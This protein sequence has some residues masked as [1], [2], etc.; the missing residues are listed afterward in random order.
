[1]ATRFGALFCS[2]ARPPHRIG[3]PASVCRLPLPQ[4]WGRSFGLPPAPP[5]ES[6][7][8]LR[9]CRP[10]APQNWGRSF[11]LPP[12]PPGN[13]TPFDLGNHEL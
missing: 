2:A 12:A 3:D 7:T 13:R 6:G 11:G 9:H 5:T 1:M 8:Q 10:P 4:N